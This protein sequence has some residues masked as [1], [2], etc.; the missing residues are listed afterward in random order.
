MQFAV[1]F[2]SEGRLGHV[3]IDGDDALVAA[4]KLK[5]ECPT[6]AILY[7]RPR[8]RRG[9]CRHPPLSALSPN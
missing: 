7:V 4:L 2:K 1:G 5:A 3:L 8:N 9:D 6:A